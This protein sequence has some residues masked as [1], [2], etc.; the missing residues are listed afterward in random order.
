MQGHN[1]PPAASH[2]WLSFFELPQFLVEP[3]VRAFRLFNTALDAF[4]YDVPDLVADLRAKDWEIA[5]V[6]SDDSASGTGPKSPTRVI[7]LDA[8]SNP[9][10]ALLLI[11]ANTAPYI[12][13][14]T[15]VQD[16]LN[17]PHPEAHKVEVATITGVGSSAYGSAAMAWQ[18]SVAIGKP[19][20][21][22]IPGYGVAD[23]VQQGLGGWFAFG[24]H[25]FLGTKSVVQTVAAAMAPRTASI[26]RNLAASVPNA[27]TINGAPVFEHGCGSSDVLHAL[28]QSPDMRLTGLVGHSKGALA[29]KNALRSLSPAETAGLN[30]VTLGCPI[31]EEVTGVHYHQVL[32]AFDLLGQLN[33]WGNLPDKW[34][35][36]KHTTNPYGVLPLGAARAAVEGLRIHEGA[37]A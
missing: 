37:A 21:A 31:P 9:E 27:K 10:G 5:T 15:D 16:Y 25:D 29:I 36:A 32:G 35:A 11:D 30:V 1:H 13:S 28:L 4:F 23:L 12:H 7:S 8:L 22:I 2:P 3:T 33:M 14:Y 26:G 6:A 19:V 18:M 24:L 34:V 20:L 17:S